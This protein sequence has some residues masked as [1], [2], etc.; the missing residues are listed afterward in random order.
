MLLLLLRTTCYSAEADSLKAVA[1]SAYAAEDYKAAASLYSRVEP[2]AAVCY[3]IGNCHYRMDDVARA[4]LWYE[5]AAMLDPGDGDIRF[6]LEMARGKTIDKVV[7]KHELFFVGWCRSLVDMA[8][9]DAWGR[10]SLALFALALA[11]LVLCVVLNDITL[12]KFS[13]ALFAVLLVLTAV[14]N[15]CA[16]S[17]RYHL[18]HRT[19]AIVMDASAVVKSTPSPSGNDLFVLHEGT[20]VEIKDSTLKGWYEIELA[21]GKVGWLESRQVEVI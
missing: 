20:K 2:S 14:G 11:C 1:D 17:Q 9:A 6:N 8:S 7:P 5:R 12:R 21:D 19:G 15:L 4:I 13:L 18:L 16:Y 10:I 3:N